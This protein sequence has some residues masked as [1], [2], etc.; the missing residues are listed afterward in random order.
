L[1]PTAFAEG[2]LAQ[3]R[4]AH[5]TDAA[6]PTAAESAA[7]ERAGAPAWAVMVDQV[8]TLVD[9]AADFGE[10]QGALAAAYGSLDS[11]DL[12]RVMEAA[13]ALAELKGLAA[14]REETGRA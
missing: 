14:V 13:F 2:A 4:A 10:L 1:Q 11:A 12:V 8:R 9:Q 3:A 5:V 7:L 6:D